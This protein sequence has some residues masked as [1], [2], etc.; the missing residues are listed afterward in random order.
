MANSGPILPKQTPGERSPYDLQPYSPDFQPYPGADALTVKT[1]TSN[2][3][4]REEGDTYKPYD[5]D[6]KLGASRVSN[7][8]TGAGNSQYV[9]MFNAIVNRRELPRNPIDNP[10]GYAWFILSIAASIEKGGSN[11]MSEVIVSALTNDGRV[12][13]VNG[14]SLLSLLSNFGNVGGVPYSNL[15]VGYLRRVSKYFEI[16]RNSRGPGSFGGLIEKIA[17]RNPGLIEPEVVN[18]LKDP[19]L[20]TELFNKVSQEMNQIDIGIR[21]IEEVA[22]STL[23]EVNNSRPNPTGPVDL[24]PIGAAGQGTPGQRRQGG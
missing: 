11:I 2:S 8:M 17:A 23:E 4:L 6:T 22:K 9:D 5:G 3:F 13:P 16:A 18:S 1:T 10:E 19:G 14:R 7:G 15:I 24:T 12:G 21:Q 20:K